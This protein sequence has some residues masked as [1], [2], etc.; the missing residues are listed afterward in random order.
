MTSTTTVLSLEAT[1]EMTKTKPAHVFLA[2]LFTGQFSMWSVTFFVY[3][4]IA[5][6]VL[7]A[8]GAIVAF[9]AGIVSAN[10][11]EDKLKC[12]NE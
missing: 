7:S 9:I 10:V 6:G 12:S 8:V 4:D 1:T 3:D 5:P 11:L 2:G